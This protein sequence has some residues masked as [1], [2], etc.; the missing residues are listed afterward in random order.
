LI[1][2]REEPGKTGARPVV[3]NNYSISHSLSPRLSPGHA[4]CPPPCAIQTDLGLII[5]L[6]FITAGP[7]TKLCAGGGRIVEDMCY[8]CMP[9]SGCI[10]APCALE[11]VSCP[12]LHLSLLAPA[13]LLAVFLFG[14][15]EAVSSPEPLLS[16]H[17]PAKGR[18]SFCLSL[19]CTSGSFLLGY[20]EPWLAL[21]SLTTTH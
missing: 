1:P 17:A 14:A 10:S 8:R 6:F 19:R 2:K 3:M 18:M 12:E 15:L 7:N 21:T 16:L 20:D 5:R 11:A 4:L 9:G 13:Q